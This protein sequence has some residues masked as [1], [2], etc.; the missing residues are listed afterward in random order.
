MTG[1]NGIS[2]LISF[3][4][5]S[6][7]RPFSRKLTT[8]PSCRAPA[9]YVLSTI[10]TWYLVDTLGRRPILL[11]GASVMAVALSLVGFF[12]YLD[13][14]YTPSMVVVCVITFNAA[15][16]YSWGPVPWCVC[17]TVPVRFGGARECLGALLTSF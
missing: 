12:L 9:V 15:F 4:P 3:S 6:S 2:T 10:P 7:L 5:F 1:I 17:R 8:T 13:R 16:G 14:S 11:S